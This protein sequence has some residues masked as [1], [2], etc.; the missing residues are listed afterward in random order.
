MRHPNIILLLD[1]FETSTEIG[2]VTEIA[3]GEL[4]DILEEDKTFQAKQ[5]RSIAIQMA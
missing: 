3:Q 1:W 5:V 4:F 2:I